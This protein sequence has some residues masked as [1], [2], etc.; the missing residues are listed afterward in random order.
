MLILALR[1]LVDGISLC[2][3]G[4][5]LIWLQAEHRSGIRMHCC[6][7]RLLKQPYQVCHVSD[8]LWILNSRLRKP[9]WQRQLAAVTT[10]EGSSD[11]PFQGSLAQPLGVQSCSHS[12]G[13]VVDLPAVTLAAAPC[14]DHQP[15][16]KTVSCWTGLVINQS[17][18]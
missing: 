10:W 14:L 18:N 13:V 17:I 1:L 8:A 4:R 6:L 11:A 15:T 2:H 3:P 9:T 5:K 7:N 16:W 12:C